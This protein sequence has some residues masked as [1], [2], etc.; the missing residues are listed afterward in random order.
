M[1]PA[2]PPGSHPAGPPA[3][4][5]RPDGLSARPAA[6][7]AAPAAPCAG[8]PSS[9]LQPPG[10]PGP[11]AARNSRSPGPP[12][13]AS[14]PPPPAA[15]RSSPAAPPPPPAVPRPAQPVPHTTAAPD[16]A[17]PNPTM[18][19]N[20]TPAPTHHRSAGGL[21]GYVGASVNSLQTGG[22]SI[23]A[24]KSTNADPPCRP[25]A[26]SADAPIAS[27]GPTSP[28]L[29]NKDLTY[30]LTCVAGCVFFV[31]ARMA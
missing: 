12:A 10:C 17:S 27:K 16:A 20:R 11:G 5:S 2:R 29:A 15:T 1:C 3:P 7:P 13:G 8:W 4:G 21:T 25:G 22:C 14:P 23:A 6:G 28:W 9:S 24:D 31:G 18:I 19:T 30:L 26:S